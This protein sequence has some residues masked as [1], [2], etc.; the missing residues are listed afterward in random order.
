MAATPDGAQCRGHG[1][2]TRMT[3]SW[4]WRQQG[5]KRPLQEVESATDCICG[6]G[7]DLFTIAQQMWSWAAPE[8]VSLE[9]E[10]NSP[11]A[12]GQHAEHAIDGRRVSIRTRIGTG[13]TTARIDTN[14][15]RFVKLVMHGKLSRQW[16]SR[17]P[18]PR[19]AASDFAIDPATA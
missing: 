16:S 6:A 13:K 19:C 3:G 4:A 18:I 12:E 15:G 8:L 10:L 11:A 9:V 7:L 1:V 17:R 14:H 2:L 5:L